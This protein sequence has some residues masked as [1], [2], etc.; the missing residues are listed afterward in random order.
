[1]I[2]VNLMALGKVIIDIFILYMTADPFILRSQYG[3][4]GKTSGK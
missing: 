1:M 3:G 2:S 4:E